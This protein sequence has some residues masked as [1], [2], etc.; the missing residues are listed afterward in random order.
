MF[1]CFTC[2]YFFHGIRCKRTDITKHTIT[3]TITIPINAK[4]I[5]GRI[6]IGQVTHHH[7]HA[8]IPV[9][10]NATNNTKNNPGSPTPVPVSSTF[11]IDISYIPP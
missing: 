8:I 1:T 7:D 2:N 6:Q 5:A 9:S 10:F 3:K 11:V 4:K